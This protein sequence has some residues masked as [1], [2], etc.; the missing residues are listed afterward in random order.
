MH[1]HGGFLRHCIRVDTKYERERITNTSDLLI[2]DTDDSVS[3]IAMRRRMNDN[4]FWLPKTILIDLRKKKKY[5]SSLLALMLISKESVNGWWMMTTRQKSQWHTNAVRHIS[6]ISWEFI[7]DIS[8]DEPIHSALT[9][10]SPPT[11]L[12]L[13]RSIFYC[14]WWWRWWVSKI[15]PSD[16][17]SGPDDIKRSHVIPTREYSPEDKEE[18][19]VIHWNEWVRK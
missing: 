5:Y 6:L 11:R 3:I 13:F 2:F 17:Y 4:R 14:L 18:I 7:G 16:W 1:W 9:H 10:S 15:L 19:F 12:P 8:F